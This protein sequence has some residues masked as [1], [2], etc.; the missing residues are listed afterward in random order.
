MQLVNKWIDL[1]GLTLALRKTEVVVVIKMR[2]P[3]VIPL[4]VGDKV[5]E[6]N[7]EVKYFGV[8]ANFKMNFFEQ[9][10]RTVDK[11]AKEVMPRRVSRR[12][13]ASRSCHA[14]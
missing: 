13:S 6:S 3:A 14:M 12:V 4:R 11:A 7:P 2:V 5:V 9:I 8:I 1:Q 10:R